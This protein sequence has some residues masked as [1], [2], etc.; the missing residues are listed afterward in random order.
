MTKLAELEKKLGTVLEMIGGL[1]TKS[2]RIED[3]LTEFETK[4]K[5]F[6]TRFEEKMS[7]IDK[8]IEK[9]V[10]EAV[11]SLTE[12]TDEIQEQMNSTDVKIKNISASIKKC[13]E[14]IDELAS[15]KLTDNNLPLILER[16]KT[17]ENVIQT[18]EN[19]Q[20][21]RESYDKRLNLLIHGVKESVGPWELKEKT[22]EI[23]SNFMRDGLRIDPESISLIDYHR[24]PQRPIFRANKKVTR[25][26]I[27][28]VATVFDKQR[29]LKSA[30]NL[31]QY[32]FDKS[33][34][35][36]DEHVSSVYITEHLP[37]ILYNHKKKLLPLFKEA[38]KRNQR[39]RWSI[40][41]GSYFLYVDNIKHSPH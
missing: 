35:S 28:K 32:N 30:K 40:E 23:L 26:I 14:N 1:N 17:L 33:T 16:I 31:K 7:N 25:P 6:E 4:F 18:N 22:K 20:I 9:K 24:L 13:N 8:L 3:K 34:S 37:R 39:T 15:H 41:N 5:E 12:R 2:D 21:M 11:E 36:A 29:I 27:I 38:K 19:D 10:A